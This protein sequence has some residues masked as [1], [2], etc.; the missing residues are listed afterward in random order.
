MA[1]L[2]TAERVSRSD[3]SDNYVF[4]RSILAY[5]H[6][7]SLVGGDVLEIGTGMGYGIELIAPS[8]HH[9]TTIDKSQA[10]DATLPDNARFCKMEVPP[11]QF[12]AESFDYVI[13][14]QVIEHIKRDREFVK[15]VSRILRKGGKFIVSTPNA[16]MSLTRNPWHIRE[17]AAEQLHNLLADD[18]SFVE[19]FGVN[20]NEKVMQYYE[21]NKRSVERIMRWDIL[22]LQHRLPR[23]ILQLPYDV[24]NRINRRRLL[25]QNN[26]LTRSIKMSD[27]SVGDITPQSFDLYFIATK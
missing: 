20:G 5:H 15:E 14:F 24:M 25:N 8:A 23:W 10:Y 13:S 19:A 12:E 1:H 18:F 9:F 26:D 4:Q 17:Y 16:P 11:L 27:Y 3:L 6:A 7:A 22:A 2:H 21:Q